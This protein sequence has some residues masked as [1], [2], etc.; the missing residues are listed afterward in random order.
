[1]HRDG[2]R[3][4]QNGIHSIDARILEGAGKKR[5]LYNLVFVSGFT[6][7]LTELRIVCHCDALV[8]DDNADA[9]TLQLFAELSDSLLLLL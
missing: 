1:M 8:I 6:Q 3:S 4:F 9:S 5:V 7:F 2:G